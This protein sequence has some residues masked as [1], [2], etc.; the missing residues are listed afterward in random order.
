MVC[1]RKRQYI[2][3]INISAYPQFDW[4]E[5][6]WYIDRSEDA[7][8]STRKL[9]HWIGVTENQGAPMTYMILPKLCH[10]IARSSVFPLL[11]DDWLSAEVQVLKVELDTSIQEKIGDKHSDVDCFVEFPEAPKVPKDIF[12]DN[13]PTSV[14][15]KDEELTP[16]ADE[17]YSLEAYE[18]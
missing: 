15:V 10:P 3:T 17:H 1:H 12:I 18:P 13:E 16:E 5:Y 9:G 14:P 6:I 7:T 4:F 11:Q 2:T 8:E